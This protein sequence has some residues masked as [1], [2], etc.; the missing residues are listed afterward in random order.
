MN[1]KNS[2]FII[3]LYFFAILFIHCFYS[4][5][6]FASTENSDLEENDN[7]ISSIEL[8]NYSD[9][10]SNKIEIEAAPT[11]N[12]LYAV[13]LS[14]AFPGLGQVYVENYWKAPIFGIAAGVVWYMVI[15]NHL[16]SRDYQKEL[17]AIVD[18]DSYNWKYMNEKRENAIDNRDLASLYLI[19]VYALAAVDA[20][21][22]A[23]LF[24]HNFGNAKLKIMPF[25]DYDNGISLNIGLNF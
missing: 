22:G 18:K 7:L 23:H 19:G 20:Y 16:K 5:L 12:P 4:N 2:K 14:F 21:V 3:Y 13:G 25:A 24:E 11:K 6:C 9:N 1:N 15:D 8:Y 10:K 17:D